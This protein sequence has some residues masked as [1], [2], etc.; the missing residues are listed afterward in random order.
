[1]FLTAGIT[2][3]S[4]ATL[5]AGMGRLVVTEDGLAPAEILVVSNV[6]PRATALEA[7]LLFKAN[8]SP[9]VLMTEWVHDPLVEKTRELGI[10]YLDSPAINKLILER[11]GVPAS[12][13][14]VLPDQAD[15]TGAEIA[16]IAEYA[17]RNRVGSLLVVTART[18]TTRTKWLLRRALPNV[19]VAVR[20]SRFDDF[21]PDRW[22]HEREQSRE[23][24]TEYLRLCNSVILGDVWAHTA[25]PRQQWAA[26][27]SRHAR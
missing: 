21:R 13:I 17:G 27:D 22:W 1:V 3:Y 19:R 11:S 15:G 18:H 7:A 20:S 5:L 23:V 24:L 12:A 16:A 6:K 2:W 14:T 26:G 4:R 25:P 8:I 9:R 10:P